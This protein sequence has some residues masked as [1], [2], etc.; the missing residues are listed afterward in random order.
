MKTS[1]RIQYSINIFPSM[2]HISLL[3]S[4]MVRQLHSESFCNP[5][6]K[7]SASHLW[8]LSA[9]NFDTQRKQSL[10]S[11]PQHSAARLLLIL[12]L[13]VLSRL[14]VASH[15]DSIS[16]SSLW[17]HNSLR[18]CFRRKVFSD[19]QIRKTVETNQ[20][21]RICLVVGWSSIIKSCH[22]LWIEWRS[23]EIL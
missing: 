18:R 9:S 16:E 2:G 7:W 14:E 17:F 23:T 22:N 3:W 19:H 12:R 11:H 6:F 4:L 10:S 8:Q 21:V 15:I 1:P 5:C 13:P 20:T